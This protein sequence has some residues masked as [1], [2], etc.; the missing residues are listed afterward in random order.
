MTSQ[1]EWEKREREEGKNM[2]DDEGHALG[3][4]RWAVR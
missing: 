4:V 3:E 1:C 2:K